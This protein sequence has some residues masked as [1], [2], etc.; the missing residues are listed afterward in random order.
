MLAPGSDNIDEDLVDNK[1]SKSISFKKVKGRIVVLNGS[2]KVGGSR[3]VTNRLAEMKGIIDKSEKG[4][5][6]TT[7]KEF[8]SS[9]AKFRRHGVKSTFP[10]W[11][12]RLGFNSKKDFNKVVESKKGKRY[13]RL[14]NKAI[15]DL[16]K[17]HRTQFGEVPADKDF[18]V[19]TRQKF[20]NKGVIFR[21]IK[22][23]IR[24]IKTGSGRSY[25]EVPF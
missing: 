19:K 7:M 8:G 10:S 24:P 16:S 11:F 2:K 6:V 14:V 3:S 15:K 13:D 5:T 25:S 1:K 17:G 9:G 18:L 20:D 23:K 22:G 4:H 12:S 21:K